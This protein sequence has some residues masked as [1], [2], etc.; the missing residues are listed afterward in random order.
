MNLGIIVSLGGYLNIWISEFNQ[1]K[2]RDFIRGSCQTCLV[3]VHF[4]N[5]SYT[6]SMSHHHTCHKW[7]MSN[8]CK[9]NSNHRCPSAWPKKVVSF[10]LQNVLIVCLLLANGFIYT[11]L[12]YL[13]GRDCKS[14]W[15]HLKR[16]I[17][18]DE[19]HKNAISRYF[20]KSWALTLNLIFSTVFQNC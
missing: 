4:I 10:Y 18:L 11:N 5:Q 20:K 2:D 17:I 7:P 12:V 14:K 8:L 15:N 1:D 16:A 3:K 6:S 13:T 9:I 19:V